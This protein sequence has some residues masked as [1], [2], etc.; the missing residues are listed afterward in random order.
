[1]SAK[2]GEVER[3]LNIPNLSIFCQHLKVTSNFLYYATN[4]NFSI[5]PNYS[6]R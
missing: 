1:M 5:I 3:I 4:L 6:E 2:A